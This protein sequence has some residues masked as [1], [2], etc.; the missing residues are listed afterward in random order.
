MFRVVVCAL[1]CALP[2]VAFG[3]PTFEAAGERAL[4]MGGAFIAV[5]DDATAAHWNPAG[6]V[7]GG[8]AGMTVGWYRFQS[9]RDDD[10]AR[11]GA[12]RSRGTYTSLGTWPVGVSYGTFRMTRLTGADGGIGVETL[13]TSQ[14]GVTILQTLVDGLVIGSTLRYIRGDVSA[15]VSEAG[16]IAQAIAINDDVEGRRTGAFDLDVGLMADMQRLR[17]GLTWKNLRSPSFGDMSTA[18]ITLPRQTRLG[19]ALLPTDGLTLAMDLDLETVDFAGDRRRTLAIGGEGQVASRLA[20][21][22]GVRWSVEG[23]RRL[24]ASGGMSVALRPGLWLDGHYTHSRRD[25]DREFGVAL[26]AGL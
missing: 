6:L 14:Y 16:T 10:A 20:I 18:A 4:G 19:V 21:R 12:A 5:A 11:A 1:F 9:G 13:R 26:R 25:D 2:S 23:A 15:A 24:V 22:S 17:V 3:Q 8:P 7:S